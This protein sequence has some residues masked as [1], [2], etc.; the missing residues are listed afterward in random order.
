MS[1]G[2]VVVILPWGVFFVGVLWLLGRL[3]GQASRRQSAEMEDGQSSSG[4]QG[5]SEG[6]DAH[7]SE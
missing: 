6:T 7:S 5:S 2:W 1:D 3:R 4:H